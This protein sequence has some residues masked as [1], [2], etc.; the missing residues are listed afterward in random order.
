MPLELRLLQ[1]L[2]AT[3]IRNSAVRS[4]A[5]S[6]TRR[7]AERVRQAIVVA[8]RCKPEDGR[9]IGMQEEVE[10]QEFHGIVLIGAY[11]CARQVV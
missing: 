4:T 7:S 9:S 2:L 8:A 1:I 5:A 3:Q 11:R 6:R 10:F